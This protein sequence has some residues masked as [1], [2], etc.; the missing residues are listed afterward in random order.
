MPTVADDIELIKLITA[1]EHHFNDLCFKIRGLASTWLLATFAGVGFLLT[2]E[3]PHAPNLVLVLCWAGTLGIFVLWLLD[4]QIYQKMLNAWFD[5]RLDIEHRHLADFP[6][7]R[8]ALKRAMPGG[9]ASSLIKFFYMI[10]AS[11]PLVYNLIA[12]GEIQHAGWMTAITWLLLISVNVAIAKFSPGSLRPWRQ[13]DAESTDAPDEA[14]DVFEIM[15]TMQA[16]RR[17]KRDPVPRELLMKV[18]NAGVQVPSGQNTQPWEFLVLQSDDAR[19]FFGNHYRNAFH[20]RMTHPPADDDR[21]RRARSLRAA[22]HLADHVAEAP[23]ILLVCGLRDW[24]FAVAD[25]QR[26]GLAPPSYGSVYPCVQNILLACRASG[27]G[28][29]LTTLHQVFQDELHEYF[30]IPTSHGVVA[31]IPIGFPTGRFGPVR[32]KPAEKKTHFDRW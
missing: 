23:V 14:A 4:L 6:Q 27:L 9:R 22:L 10:I 20:E 30:D 16:M 17:L 1:A 11:A 8:R 18:L 21:S 25:D 3:T 28:A 7:I 5:S 32:R 2:N 12:Q 29:S 26:V 31:A 19:Q 13:Q 15:S 24:P